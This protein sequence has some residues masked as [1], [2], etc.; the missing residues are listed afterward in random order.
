[1]AWLFPPIPS[2][3][4]HFS[5]LAGGPIG[6]LLRASNDTNDP[7]ELAHFSLKGVAWISPQLRTSNDHSFIVGVP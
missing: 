3:L 2:K 1:M 6:L 7:T 4:A 5:L